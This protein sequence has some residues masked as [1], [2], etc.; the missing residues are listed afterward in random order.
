M[1]LLHLCK[2]K[3]ID[4][5][6]K[7]LT[8]KPILSEVLQQGEATI[9]QINYLLKKVLDALRVPS[10]IVLGFWKKP[11]EFYHNEQYVINHCWLS[12]LIENHSLILVRFV[13]RTD[14]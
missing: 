3:I 10:E 5:S 13:S 9:Y 12:V 2:F 8:V 11:N 1:V 4:E 7:I 14:R 6:S